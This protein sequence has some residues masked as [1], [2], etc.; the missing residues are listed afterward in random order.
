[1]VGTSGSKV[2]IKSHPGPL[3]VVL[4]PQNTSIIKVI[5][6]RKKV[7]DYDYVELAVYP[8]YILGYFPLLCF[9]LANT[10]QV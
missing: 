3:C 4:G 2:K 9:A 10:L 5:V 7:Y 8:M 6:L 1:M